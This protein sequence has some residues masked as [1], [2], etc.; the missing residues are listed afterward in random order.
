MTMKYSWIWPKYG[1]GAQSGEAYRSVLNAG[2]LLPAALFARECIQNAADSAL[3]AREEG[4]A[5]KTSSLRMEFHFKTLTGSQKK[6]FLQ[7]F[8]AEQLSERK[9]LLE[10]DDG[11]FLFDLNDGKPLTIL[12]VK[13][14][15]TTGLFGDPLAGNLNS[16]L[17]K[18]LISLGD[19]TK[20]REDG[21]F[22]G[23]YGFG[24]GALSMTSR[25]YCVV[26]YSRFGERPDGAVNARLMGCG[27]YPIHEL[28]G[29]TFTGLSFFGRHDPAAPQGLAGA[30]E[31][32]DAHVLADKLQ[33]GRRGEAETGTSL[34][35][36]DPLISPEELAREIEN[37]WFP[38][39]INHDYDISVFSGD[40]R[41]PV[42]PG[43]RSKRPDLH[44]FVK[45]YRLAVKTD[46]AVNA[47]E[48]CYSFDRI[49]QKMTGTLGMVLPEQRETGD[50]QVADE[51]SHT[52]VALVRS[53]KMVIKYMFITDT[54]P[55][56]A[57]VYVAPDEINGILRLSEPPAHDVWDENANKL[58]HTFGE[59]GPRIVREVQKRVQ[60]NANHF[61][62]TALPKKKPSDNHL[63]VF[64]SVLSKLFRSRSHGS[65]I[66]PPSV[67]S[68]FSLQF[69]NGPDLNV[70]TAN[71][72]IFFDARV[73][74]ELMPDVGEKVNFTFH[75]R[76]QISED[77]GAGEELF[78]EVIAEEGE[79][80]STDSGA[81]KGSLEPGQ[82]ILLNVVSVE[83]SAD[84]TVNFVPTIVEEAV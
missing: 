43:N 66:P 31:N 76:C 9:D 53:N 32:D 13:D 22:G 38:A 77:E 4:I 27:Y 57:G 23:S 81:Y 19:R 28:S 46:T 33:I 11:C 54:P 65:P 1:L 3:L 40:Q 37:W 44:A 39:L 15:N 78:V 68:R 7:A 8:R 83:Y 75:P 12:V 62:R 61:R 51:S 25:G 24:K 14:F 69:L 60:T 48:K 5:E 10:L 49:D 34:L 67:K 79:L 71:Q 35:I 29:N 21:H 17:A 20:A 47:S 72:T 45:A 63:K 6:E 70:G 41:V 2:G 74:I 64:D 50:I 52:K 42:Q 18:L 36:P 73:K 58:R 55:V 16:H 30:L 59:T 82:R 56:A 26:A 84:W 80:K